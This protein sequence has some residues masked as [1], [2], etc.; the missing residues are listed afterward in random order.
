MSTRSTITL[1]YRDEETKY[2]IG[3]YKKIG[4]FYHHHDGYIKGGIGM[5]LAK[6][7]ANAEGVTPENMLAKLQEFSKKPHQYDLKNMQKTSYYQDH[8]DTEFHYEV[9]LWNNKL[10]VWGFSRI[11][12]EDMQNAYVESIGENRTPHWTNFMNVNFTL[13]NRGEYTNQ[14]IEILTGGDTV[15][16]MSGAVGTFTH[17]IY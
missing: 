9:Q 13:V 2:G 5:T 10:S 4:T 1:S 12:N 7:C 16:V 14:F 11:W 17:T 15:K 6:F 3:E 8:G